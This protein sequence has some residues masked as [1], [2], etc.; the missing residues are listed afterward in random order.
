MKR[1]SLSIP[2]KIAINLFAIVAVILVIS[3]VSRYALTST[4]ETFSGLIDNETAM[5][6]HANVSKIFLLRCRR[7]E[8]DALFNDDESMKKSIDGNIVGLRG[9][10]ATIETLIGKT[11]DLSMKEDVE[12]LLKVTED[13]QKGYRAAVAAPV[14][15]ERMR[16]IIPMR[17]AANETEKLLESFVEKVSHRIEG[18]KASTM[19]HA[20]RMQYAILGVSLL[21]VVFGFSIGTFITRS[22]SKPIKL[23]TLVMRDLAGGNKNV[24]VLYQERGDEIGDMARAVM[25]FKD[26][27]IK[28]EKLEAE[29]EKE[30]KVRENRA[31]AI[32]GYIGEFQRKSSE[33][34][35]SVND[36]ATQL[37]DHSR[38]MSTAAQKATDQSEIVARAA[39][40]ATMNVQ[41]VASAAEQLHSSITEIEKQ[42]VESARIAGDAVQETETTNKTVEGLAEAAQK[43]GA[44]VELI[45]DIAGQT[46]LLAL[47]ATIEAARAGEAGKGF[48]VVAQE[49]KG[50]ADQTAKATK[51]IADQ[52]QDIQAVSNNTVTA[53]RNIGKTIGQIN[54]ITTS[55]ASAV[56]EQTAAT[57]EIARSI[58]QAAT[59]TQTVSSNILGVTQASSDTNKTANLVLEAGGRLAQEGDRLRQEIEGFISKVRSV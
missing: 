15:Q 55:I 10:I 28:N 57:N 11:D 3:G 17:R 6:Q 36:S 44:V 12:K 30:R 7:E 51:E 14:G 32:E 18:V 58:E 23:M 39:G 20:A 40:D 48:A 49:V 56:E 52:I 1:R 42:V 8:K 37:Q 19:R 29:Q 25:V 59:G 50:L 16:A 41:T 31:V 26:N 54:Q 27:M 33:A 35:Q 45:N 43:I 2:Y 53:I 5:M 9:E 34:V 46:N 22:V 38:S 24:E 13:F 4:V 21:I 47:N